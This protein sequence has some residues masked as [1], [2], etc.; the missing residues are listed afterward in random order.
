MRIRGY[1]K[2]DLTI[3]GVVSDSTWYN[4]KNGP[5]VESVKITL[6]RYVK[7]GEITDK[8]NHQFVFYTN[9][10]GFFE[11][12]C[13]V[14]PYGVREGAL[15]VSKEGYFID[16]LFFNYKHSDEFVNFFI[17]LEEVKQN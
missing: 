10:S 3:S 2:R 11:G 7:N 1:A 6:C 4:H 17:K 16:T 9:N 14:S 13:T 5:S 15:I 12:G 8:P